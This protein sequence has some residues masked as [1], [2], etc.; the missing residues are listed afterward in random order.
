MIA[1]GLC[2]F[3]FGLLVG[4][5]AGVLT[6]QASELETAKLRIERAADNITGERVIMAS[7]VET[8]VE[9]TTNISNQVRDVGKNLS[10]IDTTTAIP[11][12]EPLA[13]LGK[14]SRV[15]LSKP[16]RRR[17]QGTTARHHS[18]SKRSSP[19]GAVDKSTHFL[20]ELEDDASINFTSPSST[21]FTTRVLESGLISPELGLVMEQ[22]G[23]YMEYSG[24]IYVPIIYHMPHLVSSELGGKGVECNVTANK[25]HQD[26][27]V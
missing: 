19:W 6:K 12:F 25:G 15:K 14:V 13:G 2:S 27:I 5:G 22:T 16:G 4:G 7:Y 23:S 20:I 1:C 18:R 21:K 3:L 24:Y 9:K 17:K 10:R 26:L 8:L 11:G